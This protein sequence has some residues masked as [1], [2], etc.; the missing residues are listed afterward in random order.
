MTLDLPGSPRIIHTPGHTPGSAVI[1]MPALDAVFMGDTMTTRNV[2]TG[3]VG[4]RA[5]PF[6]LEPAQAA[7]PLARLD[8]IDA[9]WVLPGHGESFDG[10]LAAVL[11]QMRRTAP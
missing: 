2:L 4:P 6:T 3:E 1:H 10:G 11:G 9:K 8:G 7:E 5:A